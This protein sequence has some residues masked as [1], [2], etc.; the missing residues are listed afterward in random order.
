MSTVLDLQALMAD[1]RGRAPGVFCPDCRQLI[2]TFRNWGIQ[3]DTEPERATAIRQAACEALRS[4]HAPAYLVEIVVP[5]GVE[6]DHVPTE[7]E[8]KQLPWRAWDA[9]KGE[10]VVEGEWSSVLAALTE[11]E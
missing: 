2:Y 1:F 5:A 8:V 10:C 4:Y 6:P 9:E 11:R 7:E 3:E